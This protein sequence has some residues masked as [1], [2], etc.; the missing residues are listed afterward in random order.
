MMLTA[1]EVER[2]VDGRSYL[3]LTRGEAKHLEEFFGKPWEYLLDRQ[4]DDFVR[5]LIATFA[6]RNGDDFMDIFNRVDVSPEASRKKVEVFLDANDVERV[7]L[8]QWLSFSLEQVDA[9]TL[10]EREAA[11]ELY[12]REQNRRAELRDIELMN[13]EY[14]TQLA[15]V[16]TSLTNAME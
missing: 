3:D 15:A 8:A 5:A 14:L 9:M 10:S 12:R 6:Q 11:R 13:M 4:S 2:I 1:E 16:V 7:A